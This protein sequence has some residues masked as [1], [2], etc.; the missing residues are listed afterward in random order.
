VRKR[1]VPHFHQSSSSFVIVLVVFA[2][3]RGELDVAD[4]CEA[5]NLNVNQNQHRSKTED[6]NDDDDEDE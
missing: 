4:W 3:G 6:E 2:I 1:L 5:K